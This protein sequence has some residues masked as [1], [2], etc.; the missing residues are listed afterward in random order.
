MSPIMTQVT[1][2]AEQKVGKG[3][4]AE[5]ISLQTTAEDSH[6]WSRRNV[7]W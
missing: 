3:E 7:V 1:S 2:L 4:T 6:G 5:K